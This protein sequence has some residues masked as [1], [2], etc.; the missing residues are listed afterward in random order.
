MLPA[1][2]FNRLKKDLRRAI[3]A[4][5]TAK[6]VLCVMKLGEYGN[7]TPSDWKMSPRTFFEMADV[8]RQLR[9]DGQITDAGQDNILKM[10]RGGASE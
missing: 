4:G 1:T 10:L 6:V 9:N 7:D 3:D 5:D 8:L 2:K